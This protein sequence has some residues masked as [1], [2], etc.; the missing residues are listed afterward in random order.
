MKLY[1]LKSLIILIA[2]L[3]L[4]FPKLNADIS[5]W[6]KD[7]LELYQNRNYNDAILNI[8]KVI[9]NDP[10]NAQAYYYIGMC[11]LMTQQFDDAID[12]FTTSIKLDS[13]NPDAF[14]NRGIAN[15]YVGNPDAAFDDFDRAILLDPNFS[16][17]YLNRGT[18]L[19]EKQDFENAEKDLLKSI[20]YDK[21]NPSA[22]YHIGR[23]K[24]SNGNREEAIKYYKLAIKYG[25]NAPDVYFDLGNVYFSKKN[26]KSAI[27][28]Y[29]NA[30]KLDPRFDKALNNRAMAYDNIGNQKLAKKD[31]ERINEITGVTFID[32]D[33]IKYIKIFPDNKAFNLKI[34]SHW[35]KKNFNDTNRVEIFISPYD[36]TEN[37][38]VLTSIDITMQTD[39]KNR[40]GIS[41]S[42]DII[43]FWRSSNEM[44]F[45]DYETNEIKKI[46]TLFKDGYDIRIFHS[47][48]QRKPGDMVY[49]HISYVAAKQDKLV[50]AYF[51]CP[52]IQLLY[53][54]PIFEEI[55]KSV[56]IPE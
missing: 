14:N 41:E 26:Y 1:N 56:T 48:I 10:Q 36:L 23:M 28:E 18:A 44:N 29:T 8:R 6:F 17:A 43:N 2:V 3:I 27:K 47:E 35:H 50:Y 16:E 7:G 31:R 22:Y 21:N 19:I 5:K 33:K 4:S 39:L 11:Y 25:M 46:K 15:G 32:K 52:N 30:I 34:P 20:K 55:M 40:Y 42:G 54:E 53:Y 37:K 12:N 51:V 9:E 13:K 49:R 45:E 38:P 24:I